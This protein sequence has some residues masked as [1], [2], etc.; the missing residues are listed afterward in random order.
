MGQNSNAS[1][2]VDFELGTSWKDCGLVPRSVWL[3]YSVI[4][5]ILAWG[6][7][8][9]FIDVDRVIQHELRALQS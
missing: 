7:G 1:G 2:E 4:M 3:I 8:K 5:I 6:R 9:H